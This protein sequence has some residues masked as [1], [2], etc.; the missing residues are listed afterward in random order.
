VKS[1]VNSNSIYANDAD[2]NISGTNVLGILNNIISKSEHHLW[3]LCHDG[4]GTLYLAF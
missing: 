1:R 3:M 4:G 2:L